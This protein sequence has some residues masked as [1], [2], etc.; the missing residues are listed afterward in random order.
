MNLIQLIYVSSATHELDA[1]DIQTILDSSVRHNELQGVTGLLLYSDG[2]FI[3]V[4][5]GEEEA[6]DET[7]SRILDD[8]RHKDIN[9]IARIPKVEREFGQWSMGFR[10]ISA[11]EVTS[12]PAYAP[13]FG[14]EFSARKIR[15]KPGLALEILRDFA[16][17]N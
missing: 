8:P 13:F 10:R 7:M 17:M 14:R 5:E 3:Q 2:N 15:A 1:G 16:R 11:S 9:I 12:N 6:V 4:L